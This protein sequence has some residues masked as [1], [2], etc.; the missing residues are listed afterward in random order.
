MQQ[1]CQ[2]SW[3]SGNVVAIAALG[4]LAVAAWNVGELPVPYVGNPLRASMPAKNPARLTGEFGSYVPKSRHVTPQFIDK[5]EMIS[6]RLGTK[7]QY[8][9]AVMAFETG[10]TYSPSIQ[11]PASK[12]TGLIQFMSFTAK[13]LGTSTSA[14]AKM[15]AVRQLN[16]V[17]QYLRPYRGRLNNLSDLYMAVLWPAAVGK[18]SDFV[19]FAAGSV[20]YRQ[21]RGFDANRDGRIT[22]AEASDRVRRFLPQRS[23]FE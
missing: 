19:L 22:V 9:M 6:K 12:A 21:N 2:R 8:L 14:L 16:Y 18:S 23:V 15:D 20:E 10:G 11:N 13:N 17:Y 1:K 5:V 4:I 3:L 7:P